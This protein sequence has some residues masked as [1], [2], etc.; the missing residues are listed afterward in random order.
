MKFVSQPSVSFDVR[1]KRE[2]E[3]A[4]LKKAME[5]EG[6]NHEAQIQD[7]RQKHSQSVEELSEQLE[8][9]K[10]V[11]RKPTHV[12]TCLCLSW[13]CKRRKKSDTRVSPSR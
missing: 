13:A 7:L 1:A 10:R 3:V 9:A 6:R 4:L 2:Q 5:E 11:E 8:Q 12:F